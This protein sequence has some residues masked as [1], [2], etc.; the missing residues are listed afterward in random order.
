MSE[1]ERIKC[2]CSH[3][4]GLQNRKCEAGVEY[5]SVK[6]IGRG[7][8]CLT[9]HRDGAKL[10]CA[11]RHLPSDAEAEEILRKRAEATKKAME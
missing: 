1:K 7:V 10:E 11:K 6:V 3:F 4:N 9:D 2:R 8:P 5:E